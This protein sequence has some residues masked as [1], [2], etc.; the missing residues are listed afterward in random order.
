MGARD[1]VRSPSFSRFYLGLGRAP[2]GMPRYMGSQ[3]FRH[4]TFD[5]SQQA[6]V[7]FDE[8]GPK[9]CTA[10]GAL[11]PMWNDSH[12]RQELCTCASKWDCKVRQARRGAEYLLMDFCW[13]ACCNPWRML[14]FFWAMEFEVPRLV[15]H[16]TAHARKMEEL[17]AVSFK[18]L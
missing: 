5:S 18:G 10:T 12:T 9:Y 6:S 8:K 7:P 14:C 11:R 3:L 2:K 4:A 17:S 15:I 16:G 13:R 1:W